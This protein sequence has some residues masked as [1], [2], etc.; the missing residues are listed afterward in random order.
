MGI[1]LVGYWLLPNYPKTTKWLSEEQRQYAAWRLAMDVG[2]DDT[3]GELGLMDSIKAAVCD[4]K[5]YLFM[6]LQHLILLSQCFQY[7]FPSVVKTLVSFRF[8]RSFSPAGP[9]QPD[10]H[11]TSPTPRATTRRLPRS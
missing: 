2:S 3:A 6:V 11:F 8:P 9:S 7:V 5:L 1:A 10:L 4:P